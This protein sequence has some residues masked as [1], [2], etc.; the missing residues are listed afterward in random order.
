MKDVLLAE[1]NK[2]VTD[3]E[4][5]ILVIKNYINSYLKDSQICVPHHSDE[6][7]FAKSIIEARAKRY[8]KI[9]KIFNKR[10]K[11]IKDN[12]SETKMIKILSYIKAEGILNTEIKQNLIDLTNNEENLNI[13]KR[14]VVSITKEF[15]FKMA[16]IDFN[17]YL[18]LLKGVKE[19]EDIFRKNYMTN[20]NEK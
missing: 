9:N 11:N 20:Y 14:L 16:Q 5:I 1:L 12:Y 15:F 2:M 3:L 10:I 8:Q 6:D 17:F 4:D 13:E 18:I 19:L 7:I